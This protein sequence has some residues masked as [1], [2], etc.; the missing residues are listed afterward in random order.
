MR[1][2]LLGCVV[3]C[4]GLFGGCS[5][6]SEDPVP[7]AEK[8]PR[9]TTWHVDG[10]AI[11]DPNGRTVI[12]RG[13]NLA[14]AHKVKPYLSSF[15]PD[16]YTRIRKEWGMNVLRFLVSWTALEPTRGTFDD[17][18]L[19]ELEKRMG[20]ARD[21]GVFVVLDMHQD[22]FGEGFLGGNGAP[23][24]ACDE[25]RYAAFKPATPW[26]WGYLDANVMACFDGLW[27]NTDIRH[28]LVEGW[29]R[30]AQR[31]VKFDNVLGFDA[32]NEPH[33]GSHPPDAFERDRLAPFYDEVVAAVRAEAKGW[34][35][36]MEPS[37][38]RNLG[39]AMNLPKPTIEGV[40]YSPH[41][42]DPAAES[43]DGFDP[44]HRDPFLF[45]VA[46]LREEANAL[47]AGLFL[48]EYGGHVD[49]P[50]IVEYMTAAYDA[51]GMAAASTAYW[52]HDRDEGYAMLNPDGSEKK[53]L[54]DVLVRPYPERVAGHLLS[55]AFDAGSKT[56]TVTFEP[57]ATIE[58]PTEIVVPARVYPS[59][60]TVDCG[61]C[62]IEEA[63]G[64]VRLR[65]VPAARPAVITIRPR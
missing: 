17:A 29:R 48:G 32:L 60:V 34:L 51:A 42:Y 27:T 65:D 47:G 54:L 59:G 1:A 38:A 52:A 9:P 2:L 63:P 8:P 64:L 31:L 43:G 37:S 7:P 39:L 14:G 22:L 21:A 24:W 58:A 26:F 62:A 53:I 36:F 4:A 55:Y 33:W 23:R 12:L 45:K 15:G 6:T 11:R 41:A 56:A 3:G 10:N 40:V 50:G 46:D 5:S 19:D 18:Y 13:V 28:R 49:K 35:F 16:E 25:S 30:I 44:S 20:W 57:D 61:G